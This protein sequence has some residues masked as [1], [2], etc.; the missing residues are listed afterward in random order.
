[1][2]GYMG[3]L[4]SKLGSRGVKGE[5]FGCHY[6][7]SIVGAAA[8]NSK[9]LAKG[10][11]Y[12]MAMGYSGQPI[13]AVYKALQRIQE[14]L[15]NLEQHPPPPTPTHPPPHPSPF[16]PNDSGPHHYHPSHAPAPTY[17][18]APLDSPS[19]YRPYSAPSFPNYPTKQ[20]Y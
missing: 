11:R 13:A 19:A 17:S 15:P 14:L 5:I 8:P 16:V 18:N 9:L 6:N 20:S 12:G 4:K 10:P 1:M 3:S 7:I 2:I